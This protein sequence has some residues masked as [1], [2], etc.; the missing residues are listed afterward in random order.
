MT[1]F[2]EKTVAEVAKVMEKR[3]VGDGEM[4][5]MEAMSLF[6]QVNQIADN[7]NIPTEN[8]KEL[9]V[10]GMERILEKKKQN[11]LKGFRKNI[12]GIDVWD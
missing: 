7:H 12:D 9:M 10:A 6:K 1:E 8:R 3:M 4:T 2:E 5:Q 11:A